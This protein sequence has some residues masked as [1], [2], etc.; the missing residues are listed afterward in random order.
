MF[1]GAGRYNYLLL[2]TASQERRIVGS[3][4]LAEWEVI[5]V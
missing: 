5:P 4:L 1:D 3:A 2:V